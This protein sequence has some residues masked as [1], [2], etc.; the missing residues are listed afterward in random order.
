VDTSAAGAEGM[1]TERRQSPPPEF[2]LID[3]IGG[4][5]SNAFL[6]D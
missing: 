1:G 2:F 4:A 6:N 3:S 5:D